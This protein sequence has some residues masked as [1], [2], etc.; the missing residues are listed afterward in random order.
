MT[1][2]SPSRRHLLQAAGLTLA[3]SAFA[4]FAARPARA[5]A[6]PEQIS[7][8][9]IG[10]G[11]T[12]LW[13]SLDVGTGAPKLAADLGTKIVWHPGFTA[14][15]PV[16][17]AIK[18]GA[19]DF[20]FATATAVVL[21][22]AARVP[23]VPLAA[24][25][26]PRNEVDLLVHTDSPIQTAADLQGK[27]IAHQNGTTGTYSLIKFLE[28]GGLRLSDVNAVSLTGAD[29]FT[30]F[31]QGSVDGWIHWQPASALALARLAGKARALPGVQ[32]Y[33]Y[34]F[35]VARPDLADAH[36]A[37]AAKLVRIIRDTQQYVAAHPD[38]TVAQWAAEGGFA[39]G[40][41]EEK[42][43]RQLIVD[44]RLSD[45]GAVALQPVDAT[46]AAATQ[47]L[48]DNFESLGVLKTKADVRGFLLAPKF[49]AVRQI[50]ADALKA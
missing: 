28:S 19:V 12:G 24:Y 30:A 27:T 40:S 29:A 43:N 15:A 7:I 47:D 35:Y 18:G 8:A 39:P 25:A 49:D 2:P 9:V 46:A 33:D 5:E 31:A 17:E 45:S 37:T 38:E 44:A 22:V 21:A 20:S 36:P 14:S 13:G 16:M 11:R 26:L 3:G 32:T 50:V 4:T 6:P 1:S 48:A 34:A 23:I 42:V 41:L 10:D